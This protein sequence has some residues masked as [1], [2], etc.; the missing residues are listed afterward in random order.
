MSIIQINQTIPIHNFYLD[1]KT[2]VQ[3][4]KFTKKTNQ[5]C[6]IF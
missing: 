2:L 5:N 6:T 1:E 3:F 4:K